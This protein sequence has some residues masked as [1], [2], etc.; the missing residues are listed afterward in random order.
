MLLFAISTL[1][2]SIIMHAYGS[3][4]IWTDKP[5]YASWETVTIFGSGFNPNTNINLIITRPDSVVD[6]GSTMSD[7]SGNFTYYYVLNG[8]AGTYTVTATDGANSAST[9][10]TEKA[11]TPKLWGYTLEPHPDWTHGDVKGYYECEWVPYKIEVTSTMKESHPLIVVVHHDYFDGTWHGLDD[12]RSWQMWRN[13]VPETPSISG[14]VVDGWSSGIQQLEYNWTLT[15]NTDDNCTLMVE[16]HIAIGASNYPGSK[17][18][19]SINNTISDTPISGGHRDVPIVVTGPPP[20]ATVIVWKYE[21]A[22]G[23]LATT[24]DW[25]PIDWT[26]HLLNGTLSQ[27]FALGS[28]GTI[29]FTGQSGSVTVTEA[30]VPGWVHLNATSWTQTMESGKTYIVKFVNFKV[31]TITADKWDDLDGDGV[32]DPLEPEISGWELTLHCPNGTDFTMDSPASW[33]VRHGGK[34]TITEELQAG[35]IHTTA[36]SVDVTVQSGS[37]PSTVWFGNFKV[38]T[39]TADKWN[40]LDGDGTKDPGEPAIADW[41]FSIHCPNGAVNTMHSPA[42]WTVIN[43]G[44]YTITEELQSG[45]VHTTASSV[46]VSVQSGDTPSTV[47]FG[48]FKPGK[49]SG[50]KFDD[51][52]GNGVWDAG[53]SALSG[54]TISLSGPVSGSTTTDVN[55]YYEFTGLTAGTY[56]V[57][58]TVKAGWIQTKPAAP[59]TYSAAITSGS[60][61]TNRDFGN[62]KGVPPPPPPPVGGVWVPINKFDLVAPWI[63]LAS[64]LTVAAVSIVYVKRRKKQQK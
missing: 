33:V 31:V 12:V 39:I 53:E 29:T 26:V 16:T 13:G 35:W 10:F 46:D 21:D 64:S 55:G 30:D 52:N 20:T 23:N 15:I 27:D 36:S 14:P 25:T 40:D 45:W 51:V 28:D 47:W 62:F 34:Y 56:T 1:S 32:K 44:T 6:T 42:S 37:T 8:I 17:V 43:G 4:V 3:P 7:I 41:D 60:I 54:W 58:E 5:D 50:H 2:I 24:S 59:G 22:D 18:H 9:T 11:I 57:S 48:N 49:I 19:T 63:G 61:V 38:V